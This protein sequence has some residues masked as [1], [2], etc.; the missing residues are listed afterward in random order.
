M[1]QAQDARLFV[2]LPD[3]K[4]LFS[5]ADKPVGLKITSVDDK[6]VKAEL[7]NA[8]LVDAT[9]G[10]PVTTSGSFEGVLP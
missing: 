9:T 8:S 4:V 5:E 1:F 2:Q 10:Q 7:V 6:L 3:G